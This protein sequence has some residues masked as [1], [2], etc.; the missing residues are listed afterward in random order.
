MRPS[1]GV[2]ESDTLEIEASPK[3]IAVRLP[4][5]AISRCPS[6]RQKIFAKKE[7]DEML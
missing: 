2:A 5:L 4:W 1:T 7:E 6:D 3:R